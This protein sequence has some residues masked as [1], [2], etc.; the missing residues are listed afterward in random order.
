MLLFAHILVAGLT[1]PSRA[2][3]T[4][5]YNSSKTPVG[6]PWNTYNYCNAPH[7]N[8]AH[9]TR[10][11]GAD[12]GAEL[13]YLNVVM[14][15]HKTPLRPQ[16]TPDNL[17]PGENALNPAVGW[18]CSDFLQFNYG[19]GGAHVYHSTFAPASH[20]FLDQMWNGTCDEGQL[21]AGGLR[22]AV[23]HGKDFWAVYHHKLGF[24]RSVDQ[25]EIWVRTSTEDRTMQVASGML[26]GMDPATAERSWPVFT[27]PS[28]ID[29]MVPSYSCPG[30]DAIRAA[31]QSVPTWTDHLQQNSDLKARLDATLGTAGLSAWSS[32]YDHFFDTF[33][34]RTCN[35]HTLPCNSTG[36]CVSQEDADRVFAI[37]DFE[38][39]YI[40]NAA[41]NSTT[42]N[43]LTFG[44]FFSELAQNFAAFRA[45]AERHRVRLHVGH[46]G[47]MVR[48][49][50]G[51]GLGKLAPLRWP[52]L[53]S[54]VVMEVWKTGG[55][56]SA[57]FVRVMHEGTPV[58]SL[59]WMPIDDFIGLLQAQVPAD[60]LQQC[61]QGN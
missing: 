21:T 34:S 33:A 52:A 15:H 60:I 50:S 39:N 16:R 45:G 26:F 14:R 4:G 47:S 8:A 49:A 36:A 9:Y 30:A 56:S 38:Y 2:T 10:P 32:W 58:S 42:Y 54:E 55:K 20:P 53:G 6:L 61:T 46:D 13:V 1:V 18:D 11:A 37:G 43:Q 22:D 3:T 31:Y 12:A 35:G 59:Q 24:L 44:V 48:L 29:S 51:L 17:Y 19:G 57:L 27:Q 40:W 28:T 41:Q 7:V 5:V 23:Q 25:S